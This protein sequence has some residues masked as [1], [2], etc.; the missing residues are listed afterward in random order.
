[1]ALSKEAICINQ[2][3]LIIS[4]KNIDGLLNRRHINRELRRKEGKYTKFKKRNTNNDTEFKE[5]FR[6]LLEER[7][8]L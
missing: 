6:K 1:M 3:G 8:S 4:D 2:N 5:K 7:L